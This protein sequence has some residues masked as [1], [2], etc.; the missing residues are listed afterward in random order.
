MS[1]LQSASP[2]GS[3]HARH[4]PDG[5]E[6]GQRGDADQQPRPGPARRAPSRPRRSRRRRRRSPRAARAPPGSGRRRRPTRPSHARL[7]TARIARAAELADHS[8][9]TTAK[10]ATDQRVPADSF[11]DSPI[12]VEQRRPEPER[13]AR[14]LRRA[15]VDRRRVAQDH[16][17]Q[18]RER[19]QRAEEPEREGAGEQPAAVAL[20]VPDRS[21]RVL[22]AG[23]PRC[24]RQR[25]LARA[26]ARRRRGAPACSGSSAGV[27]C[28]RA[29]RASAS[30]CSPHAGPRAMRRAGAWAWCIHL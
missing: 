19:Q 7:W 4:E 21:E 10:I 26:I 27:V 12:D 1:A 22:V 3:S 30:R 2:C 11:A 15:P 8:S 29:R 17:D 18:E 9:A 14:L 25:A 5:G 6:G 20:V 16:G 23:R 24:D 13:L 28:V